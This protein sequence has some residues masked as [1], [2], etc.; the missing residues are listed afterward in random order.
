MRI[1]S[2]GRSPARRQSHQRVVVVLPHI[3]SLSIASWRMLPEAL[4]D[5]SVA[6]PSIWCTSL[7]TASRRQA[8][9]RRCKVCSCRRPYRP[10]SAPGIR[11]E[12]RSAVWSVRSSRQFTISAQCSLKMSGRRPQGLSLR[13]RYVFGPTTTP[14]AQAPSRQRLTCRSSVLYCPWVNR[15]G[16]T[17]SKALR[18]VA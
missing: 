5:T 16:R 6:T 10:G 4:P 12:A 1:P 8:R 15:P 13:R 14:R 2:A 11:P 3:I 9:T 17:E 7:C 18:T